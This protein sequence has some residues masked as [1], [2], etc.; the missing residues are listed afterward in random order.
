MVSVTVP[1]CQT[2]V[3]NQKFADPVGTI[4]SNSINRH[5]CCIVK[6]AVVSCK[7]CNVF[8]DGTLFFCCCLLFVVDVMFFKLLFN[9]TPPP[10]PP[11]GPAI[12][13]YFTFCWYQCTWHRSRCRRLLT[14]VTCKNFVSLWLFYMVE[15][16]SKSLKFSWLFIF[17]GLILSNTTDSFDLSGQKRVWTFPR[18]AEWA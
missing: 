18:I 11:P 14:T 13:P 3:S 9:L 6:S 16:K 15:S 17:S 8:H 4:S 12:L 7:F 1:E 5:Q 2:L 10:P